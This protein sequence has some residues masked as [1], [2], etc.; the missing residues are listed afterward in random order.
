LPE[1]TSGKASITK[2]LP[3][4]GN[5]K[6]NKNMASKKNKVAA[7]KSRESAAKDKPKA[8]KNES[9]E[10]IKVL[11]EGDNNSN[12]T[13]V[14]ELKGG[15]PK[16][17]KN[18]P[19][20]TMQVL[21]ENDNNL[22]NMSVSELKVDKP[23]SKLAEKISL[24][25]DK[26]N[27]SHL[28][29]YDEDILFLTDKHRST[30]NDL[31]SCLKSNSPFC[32]LGSEATSYHEYYKEI[33]INHIRVKEKI[34]LL[35]FDPKFGDDLSV[36]INKELKNV[37]ISLIGSLNSGI[38]R[39]VLIIDNENFAN[40]LDWELIDSLRLELK[41][42]N[43]GVF[44]VAPAVLIDKVK[45]TSTVSNFKAF[46]LPEIKKSELKE[47]DQY[48]S[49]DFYK[50]KHLETLST[51]FMKGTGEHLT[52]IKPFSEKSAGFWHKL[53]EYISRK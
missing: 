28:E 36:I 41:V 16:A 32:F 3:S 20:E 29:P 33:I 39:K 17:K 26:K 40:D 7:K 30:I 50:T 12:D 46:Y 8:R 49:K 37:D 25:L 21:R 23:T 35:Y 45:S 9:K 22:D 11:I 14:S 6:N 1:K 31:I 27:A 48:V 2:D 43:I 47:L 13:P 52:G 5:V 10:T 38:S 53:R 18:E 51:L 19:K 34:D 4:G 44:C 24:D 42:V 15:N